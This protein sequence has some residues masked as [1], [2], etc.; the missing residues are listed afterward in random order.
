MKSVPK[1]VTIR[2][3]EKTTRTAANN[4]QYLSNIYPRTD[5]ALLRMGYLAGGKKLPEMDP[6]LD[7]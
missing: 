1:G 3:A 6:M 4:N 5:M 2:R 7:N